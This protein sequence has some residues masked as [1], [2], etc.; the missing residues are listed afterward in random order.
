MFRNQYLAVTDKTKLHYQDVSPTYFNGL[1]V[2][3]HPPLNISIAKHVSAEI[4]LIGYILNP[5]NPNEGNSGI[6]NN[7][8]VTCTTQELFFKEI[9]IL[10]G[11]Y[12]LIYKNE[13]SFL[14]VGDTC[15][16]RQLYYGQL[17]HC[18]ILTSSPRM[19]L[20]Y[21]GLDLQTNQLKK[22]FINS[23]QYKKKESAWVGNKSIDDRLQKV[24]PNHYLDLN[25][26]EVRRMPLSPLQNLTSER[27]ILD[28]SSSVL[29]GTF[30]ALSKRYE[31]IQ[32]L[33]AGW[34]T[35]TLLSAS[36]EFKDK[37]QFYIFSGEKNSASS[38]TR[39]ATNLAGK[40]GLNFKVIKPDTLSDEFLQEYNKEHVMPRI[41]PKTA[42]IQYHYYNSNN[43]KLM[44]VNGNGGEI[45]RC[46]YGYTRRKISPEMLLLFSGYPSSIEFVRQEL[47][48]W[49]VNASQFAEEHDIPLLDLFYWE[50]RMGNW[51]ALYPF[52]QDIAMEEISPF[53]NK[54]LISALLRIKASQRRSPNYTFFRKLIQNLWP[55]TLSEP[56]NPDKII[57]KSIINR[58]SYFSYY[59]KRGNF[60]LKMLKARMHSQACN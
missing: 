12:V 21:F 26:I 11:R 55:D 18:T 59:L 60:L 23:A 24:L 43:P 31:L 39:I 4:L 13:S 46:Y 56:I 5:L 38:D 32:P 22:D 53:N 45:V 8:A 19:F 2:F 52:E 34:D 40:L 25:K 27:S 47:E 57:F 58:N 51:G 16:L 44:N 35:R 41:L 1:Y 28:F 29:K 7:L 30:T 10:S 6:V 50:Q 48:H 54:S 15:C 14:A 49:F 36:R 20:E 3:A 37:I 17:S 42:N 33:T 9:Q